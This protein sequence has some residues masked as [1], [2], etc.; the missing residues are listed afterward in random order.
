MPPNH[1]C[2]YQSQ[3][4][5]KT[6]VNLDE[7]LPCTYYPFTTPQAQH[8]HGTSRCQ[9]KRPMIVIEMNDWILTVTSIKGDSTHTHTTLRSETD[10]HAVS[11]PQSA[12]PQNAIKTIVKFE[13]RRSCTYYPFTTPRTQNKHCTSG[14]KF[15]RPKIV[16]R[17]HVFQICVCRVSVGDVRSEHQL[18][19]CLPA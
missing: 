9:F 8:T 15:K 19:D 10:P 16:I 3:N 6:V 5:I 11:N 4:A 17:W 13:E 1:A 2:L 12:T 14:C 7:R 18:S